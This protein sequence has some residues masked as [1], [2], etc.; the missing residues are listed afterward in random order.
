MNTTRGKL[1]ILAMDL[2]EALAIGDDTWD[3]WLALLRM[4]RQSIW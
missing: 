2:V 1:H 3:A 4:T